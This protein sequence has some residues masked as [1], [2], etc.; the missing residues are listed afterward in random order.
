MKKSL[1]ILLAVVAVFGLA[2]SCGGGG[3]DDDDYNFAGRWLANFTLVTAAAPGFPASG[4][5]I[6]LIAQDG[7]NIAVRF[8]S[9][10]SQLVMSGTCDP[11][12]RT[13]SATGMGIGSAAGIRSDISGVGIDD[14]S[15]TGT[16][17]LTA[18]AVF[19]QYNWTAELGSRNLTI[20]TGGGTAGAAA[21]IL[22]ALA[23]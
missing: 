13:F 15:M 10:G 6:L 7:T 19:A 11:Q 18:G 23:Q 9:V 4:P 21:D 16:W 12:A 5:D 3:D 1:Y 20:S 8:E 2:V 22:K 17:T 14:N